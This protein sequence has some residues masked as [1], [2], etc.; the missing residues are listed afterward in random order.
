MGRSASV[1][2]A[3]M[4]AQAYRVVVVAWEDYCY[5]QALSNPLISPRMYVNKF[6]K[7]T[8]SDMMMLMLQDVGIL[9]FLALVCVCS[10]NVF[11]CAHACVRGGGSRL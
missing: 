9:A 11:V 10:A 6:A 1:S 5:D 3:S 8:S 4:W 7:G 2:K